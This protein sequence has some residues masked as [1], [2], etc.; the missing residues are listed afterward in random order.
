MQKTL[1]FI[2]GLPRS[3]S[4]LISNVLK[5]NPEIHSESVSS[6]C[7]SFASVNGIWDLADTSKEYYNTQAK[8]GMMKAM[9]DG[10]YS[11]NDRS[12]VFDKD[13]GWISCIGLLEAVMDKQVKILIM[14]RNP[15]EIVTSFEKLR[16]SNPLFLSRPDQA[17]REG[18]SIASRAYYYAG[19]D[20]ALGLSHRQLSDAITMGYLDRMLFVDYNLF[21]GTPKSQ[22]K[23]IY[24]FFELPQF[25]HNFNN[26]VQEETY[27]DLSTGLPNLHKIKPVVEKTVTNCVQY[28]G[29]ELYQQYNA[30]IFWN[31]WI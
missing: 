16:Q 25:D 21:C 23:R 13:R 18:S 5:Q 9:L 20:G 28:L 10:H 11:H 3:G 19:P 4:T 6:L 27:N 14:V 31:A 15:A 2:A 17:L 8:K 12:I 30:Q 26:V 29:L 1:Y 24:D 22:T 7:T